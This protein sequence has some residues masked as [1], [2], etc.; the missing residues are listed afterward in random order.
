MLAWRFKK[1]RPNW[2]ESEQVRKAKPLHA[3]TNTKTFSVIHAGPGE[4]SHAKKRAQR[5]RKR[6]EDRRN[7]VQRAQGELGRHS[8]SRGERDVVVKNY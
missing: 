8:S 3:K 6:G 4:K 7:Y 1:K 2:R 5:G